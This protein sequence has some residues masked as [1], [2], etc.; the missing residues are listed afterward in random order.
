MAGIPRDAASGRV[1]R[2]VIHRAGAA[3][4]APDSRAEHLSNPLRERI[5]AV[6]AFHGAKVPVA[7]TGTRIARDVLLLGDGDH[8][9][10]I[11]PVRVQRTGHGVG[12]R[13]GTTPTENEQNSGNDYQPDHSFPLTSPGANDLEKDEGGNQ[14][15]DCCDGHVHDEIRLDVGEFG[16][17]GLEH[18]L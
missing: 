16:R 18:G 17:N 13:G 12:G 1:G 6:A 14:T 11:G 2:G 3:T 9:A 8:A 4:S 5:A 7:R 15:N 10:V